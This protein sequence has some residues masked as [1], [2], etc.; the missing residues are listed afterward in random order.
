MSRHH[1]PALAVLIIVALSAAVASAQE[2]CPNGDFENGNKGWSLVLGGYGALGADWTN[3]GT[4]AVISGADVHG[5]K[6][7]LVLDSNGVAGE[8]DVYSEPMAVKPGFGYRL[9]SY[10]KQYSGEAGYKVTIDWQDATNK[11]ISYDND[12]Q[13]ANK[14]KDFTLHGGVFV[15]PKDAGR[16]VLI[17]GVQTKT[18]CAF[19]DISFKELG[20][21]EALD[22]RPR[23]DGDGTVIGTGPAT[24]GAKGTGTW[25]I[26]Y[27]VG[28]SGLPSGGA[29]H[30]AR[31]NVN[32]EWP[33]FQSSKPAKPDFVS[34]KADR[35]AEFTIGCGHDVTLR[36]NWPALQPGD[37]V[38]VTLN[39]TA[40]RK[41][42]PGIAWLVETDGNADG[43]FAAVGAVAKFDVVPGPPM[44]NVLLGPATAEIG[45][46][47]TL[48]AEQLDPA[49]NVVT[50]KGGDFRLTADGGAVKWPDHVSF[51]AGVPARATVEATFSKA[52]SQTLEIDGQQGSIGP[53]AAAVVVSKRTAELAQ[54]A[55]MGAKMTG[56]GDVTLANERLCAVIPKNPDGYGYVA[57]YTKIGGAWQQVAALPSL[58]LIE[59]AGGPPRRGRDWETGVLEDGDFTSDDVG[60]RSGSAPTTLVATKAEAGQGEVVLIG[61]ARSGGRKQWPFSV[62]LRLEPG[63]QHLVT[64]LSLT[65]TSAEAIQ[66]VYGP[67]L[68]AGEG[69]LGEKRV[70][71]LFPGLEYMT[72]DEVSS[73]DKGVAWNISWRFEPHPY[74]VTVPIMAVAQPQSVVALSW[75]PEQKWDGIHCAPQPRFAAPNRPANKANNLMALAAANLPDDAPRPPWKER[76]PWVSAPGQKV[77]LSADIVLLG[78]AHDVTDAVRYY[79]ANHPLPK[80]VFPRS[81]AQD[82]DLCSRGYLE[83]NWVPKDKGWFPAVGLKPGADQNMADQMLQ[84]AL[85]TGDTTLAARLR[86]Q[87]A[88]A[89]G[90]TPANATTLA[91]RRGDPATAVAGLRRGAIDCAAGQHPEGY[92][93]FADIYDTSGDKGTLA[94]KDDVE[95]GTCVF[96]LGPILN[97]ALVSGDP[98]ALKVG[99][100]TLEYMK[101]FNRP[102]G[103]ESWEVPLCN[104]NLR[105]AALACECYVD[106]Y[107]LTGNK[108]YL[109]L[110]RKWAWAGM[111][112]IYQWEAPSRPV[113]PGA[114]ISV[115]GTTFYQHPW[116]GAAVQ[117]VGLVYANSL[118]KLATVDD[119][120]PWRDVSA[121]IVSSAM[122]QQKTDASPCKHVGLYPDSY[123]VVKGED[124][125]EWCLAPTLLAQNVIGLMGH[126][127]G[128]E[129][130]IPAEEQQIRLTTVAQ[131]QSIKYDA[132]A[133]TLTADLR[134]YPGETA[135]AVIFGLSQPE[136][137]EFDGQA[138]APAD[139]LKAAATGWA[140]PKHEHFLALKL[141]WT[142]ETAKLVLHGVSPVAFQAVQI[143]RTLGNGGFEQGLADWN[144]EAG[145]T[146]D[147]TDPHTG[148]TALLLTAPAGE[149]QCN[150]DPVLVEGGQM[151]RLSSWVKC[152]EG[153]GGYKV[154]IDWRDAM[155]GHIAFENDWAGNDRPAQYAQHGGVFRAPEKARS[156]VIIL[157]ARGG[158]YL[159][160]DVGLVKE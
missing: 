104:P 79:A 92:W 123:Y 101:R 111:A 15:A 129:T 37:K 60:P 146:L 140:I 75:N 103:A 157:G 33:E 59:W 150:S 61:E 119:S 159:M 128:I 46:P 87:V 6:A 77:S 82:L 83:T 25:K 136:S 96:K 113:M 8:V 43:K 32:F 78:D 13:G 62:K 40:Q 133:K 5:G 70:G 45:R 160:D 20:P 56:E 84:M 100:R 66:Q 158:K 141:K 155:G 28:Q 91:L 112:F 99:V 50:G 144:P 57:L 16:A 131:T 110:A 125:Y 132:A 89:L 38:E 9:A 7:A 80:P 153:G 117:W 34:V 21:A 156:A 55:P 69:G 39:A 14:P 88:E 11:H 98:E 3:A 134:Y 19:D 154:T 48:I 63:K 35:D 85:L 64:D 22:A 12:W 143:A 126:E 24:V 53:S 147:T 94:K 148:K 74:K 138:L 52:G 36:L 23:K 58:G 90:S 47:V 130:A 115:F 116:F 122:K 137:A 17:L 10:I 86:A 95:L 114:S 106:G 145:A 42:E 29:I 151:Y 44:E 68:C 135:Q 102:A 124:Y 26:T 71:A 76:K 41:P 27:T 4:H 139:D 2:L 107:R 18:K 118:Q 105:A 149:V 30:I 109:E 81:Y 1:L 51:L 54:A 108:E 31:S 67:R 127:P 65:P 93:T 121:L 97:W 120:Y 142:G 49:G 73:D 72:D 152:E